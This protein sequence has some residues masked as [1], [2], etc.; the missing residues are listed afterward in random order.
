MIIVHLLINFTVATVS[1]F[2]GYYFRARF[3]GQVRKIDPSTIVLVAV[4]FVYVVSVL[5]DIASAEYQ[6]PIAI[7]TI[8]GL[9]AG[10]FFK[11]IGKNDK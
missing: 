6:T 5:A 2:A 7:H 11:P 3:D 1:F 4:T 10:F 9:V 8:M